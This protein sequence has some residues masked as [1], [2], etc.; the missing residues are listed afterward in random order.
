MASA[1]CQV[2]TRHGLPVGLFDDGVPT[3]LVAATVR[4]RS[5]AGGVVVVA[6]TGLIVGGALFG[7]GPTTLLSGNEIGLT[8]ARARLGIVVLYLTAGLAGLAAVGS[9]SEAARLSVRSRAQVQ[10][11]GRLGASRVL[12]AAPAM[13]GLPTRLAAILAATEKPELLPHLLP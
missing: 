4:A 10:R 2:L 5:A 3:P 11:C 13:A 9:N 1:M 7:L 8:E 6:G 12:V